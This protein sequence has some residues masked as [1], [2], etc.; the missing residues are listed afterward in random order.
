MSTAPPN[1]PSNA[2][3]SA[4]PNASPTATSDPSVPDPHLGGVWERVAARVVDHVLVAVACALLLL[5]LASVGALLPQPGG[6]LLGAVG[7]LV[8]SAL[9]VGYF[10]VL[11]SRDGQTLGKRLLGLRVVDHA[12]R[13]PTREQ[14][15]RRNLWT[16]LGVAGVVPV[17]GGLVGALATTVAA[18]L[19]LLGVL[20]DVAERR[21]WHD[22]L[23]GGTRVLHTR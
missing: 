8:A 18:V 14:A 6:Y 9:T 16:G 7:T 1:T 12:G 2:T 13:V 5:P 11:E 21:G 3:P 4:T 17:V 15:L 20:S 23:A 19:I 10:T 22:R